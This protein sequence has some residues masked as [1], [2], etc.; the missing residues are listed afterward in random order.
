[1]SCKVEKLDFQTS[2]LYS[3]TCLQCW[4]IFAPANSV[5]VSQVSLCTVQMDTLGP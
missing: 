2:Q 4:D 3:G 5:L 1:M